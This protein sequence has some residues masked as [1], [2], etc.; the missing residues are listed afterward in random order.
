[1]EYYFI[2]ISGAPNLDTCPE[3]DRTRAKWLPFIEKQRQ[4]VKPVKVAPKF[5]LDN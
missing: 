3:N 4:I 2:Q 5:L 1:V